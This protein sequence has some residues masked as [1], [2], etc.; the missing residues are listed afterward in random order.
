MSSRHSFSSYVCA[1]LEGNCDI[2]RSNLEG[3]AIPC[4][5]SG[6]APRGSL[7][8]TIHPDKLPPYGVYVSC[9]SSMCDCAEKV[10]PPGDERLRSISGWRLRISGI[11]RSAA[12]GLLLLTS[13]SQHIMG[14]IKDRSIKI[15]V[16]RGGTFT[17]QHARC[18]R[19]SA[20]RSLLP[21]QTC[22]R[23]GL[24]RESRVA[25]S[26]SSS[27]RREPWPAWSR[28][29]RVALTVA[30]RAVTSLTTRTRRER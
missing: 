24:S 9:S 16:D 15:A 30:Y 18:E 11:I 8:M 6:W 10:R 23:R 21:A 27:C 13:P 25:R 17:G 3:P 14:V 2:P 12:C 22:T 1:F 29:W 28:G 20:T 19:P 5:M 4:R 7:F 26:F